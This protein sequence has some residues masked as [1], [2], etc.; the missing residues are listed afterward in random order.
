MFTRSIG[1]PVRSEG[2]TWSAVCCAR[3][4]KSRSAA[5]RGDIKSSAN[6]KQLSMKTLAPAVR[7]ALYGVFATC[8]VGGAAVAVTVVPSATAANDPASRLPAATAAIGGFSGLD[9][10]QGKKLRTKSA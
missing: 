5:I 8:L 9:L 7:R 4:I 6:R 10:P 3:T 1:D 2:P